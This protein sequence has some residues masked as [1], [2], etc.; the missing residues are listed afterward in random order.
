MSGLSLLSISVLAGF[1]CALPACD[2]KPVATVQNG[3]YYGV[4]NPTFNQD[5][6]LGM[7]YAQPPTGDLRF[8]AP[9]PLNESWDGLRNA[10]EYSPQCFGYGSDTW[11][12]GNYVSED[13]LTINVI[14]PHG[15]GK[16]ETKL[17]VA[18][19]IH[20]GGLTN[21]GSSDP[22]YN[23]SRIV[24][25]SVKM[26]KPMIAVS[27]NYRLQA[28]GF[29]FS[30]EI[31]AAGAGNLGFRDQHL[32]IQWVRDNIAAF[33]GDPKQVTLWGESAGARSV[34]A[35]LLAFG[36]R[37]EGLYR[38][39]IMQSGT[40]YETDFGE[41]DTGALTWQ[42]YYN[43]IVAKTNCASAAD[44]LQCLREV[45]T[46][47]LSNILNS[48]TS[49]TFTS[50]TI[51][52]DFIQAPR[53]QLIRDGKFVHVPLIIGTNFDEGTTFGKKGINTTEQW[54]AYL[55]SG[56]ANNET[57]A[58]L[59]T[60]YPDDP[61]VGIP[62]TFEGRPE[63][64]LASYG[65]MWKRV[66]AFA[67]DWAY[68]APRRAWAE[69]WAASGLPTYTYSFNVLSTGIEPIVGSTHFQEVAYV[70]DNTAGLGYDTAVAVNP[71]GGKPEPYFELADLMSRMWVSFVTTLD[72]NHHETPDHEEVA[73]PAYRLEEAR[74]LAFDANVTA[75]AYVQGDD[76]RKEQ[77]AYFQ[78]K[79]WT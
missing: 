8:R 16:D 6:F 41:V 61:A 58:E 79:L 45:P 70:F 64:E 28:W 31:K 5:N 52:G 33:G 66:A 68:Q 30:D 39:A 18:L 11:V 20:G 77:F 56:G 10:T 24:D 29:L 48:T 57:I 13:C 67:G 51:D 35:Q 73:W 23:L 22:R 2:S 75:L 55:R 74:N 72:P 49:P 38:A 4:L 62:A 43:T 63:G 32:A 59:S 40:G 50:P 69:A 21:G 76:Y 36:G 7:P 53:W 42:D 14:R 47:D 71:F 26:G 78:T 15:V 27:M 17:P 12:L 3:S 54:E 37:D 9:Q 1:A 19:W 44:T 65:A 34:A 60:L 46:W 25:Q